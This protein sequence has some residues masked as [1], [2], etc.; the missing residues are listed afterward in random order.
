MAAIGKIGAE[1]DEERS[2]VF[3]QTVEIVEVCDGW[4]KEILYSE[5]GDYLI[6]VKHKHDNNGGY[7]H[8]E[9]R[10]KGNWSG[11]GTFNFALNL[12]LYV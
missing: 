5:R 8:C 6:V 1:L 3:I 2:E 7:N 11:Y 10:R 12:H 4:L 9:R